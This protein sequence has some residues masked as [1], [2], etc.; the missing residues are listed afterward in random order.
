MKLDLRQLRHVLALDRY[1]NF[2]RAADAVG[3]TQPSLSRSL[4][5]LEDA[6]GA[7]LF[8][9]DRSRVEP[10]AVG[11]R[12]V[13]LARPLVDQAREV[14]RELQQLIGLDG[15]L[16]RIGAGPYAAEVSV[17][18]AVGRL[19]A[20]RPAVQVDVCVADWPELYQRLL[21][22]EV[23]VVVAEASHALDD[24]RFAVE[25][26]PTHAGFFYCRSSHPL[27]GRAELSLAELL[28]FPFATTV[29]PRRLLEFIGKG[30]P[31]IRPA[32]PDGAGTVELRVETPHLARQIV[33]ESDVIGIAVA[34]QV[35]ADLAAGRL[36]RLPLTLPWLQTSYGI[37][38]LARRSP[39]PAV[40][41]FLAILREVEAQVEP[42]PRLPEPA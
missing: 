13:E 39:S 14:E 11:A 8:D 16:L 40:C 24:D 41:E 20:R 4:I 27:A 6:L 19:A 10:T 23:D 28:R 25:P 2:A 35:D 5:S 29:V 32:L 18:T 12:L 34:G 15:G 9:R 36:T 3:I 37:L 30:D 42:A 38:L 33:L 7:K 1:R 22:E 31:S 21:A 17:G 26:L